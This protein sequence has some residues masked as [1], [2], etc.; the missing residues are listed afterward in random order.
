M[1]LCN[2]ILLFLPI[3]FS[4]TA[5]VDRN[6]LARDLEVLASD[7]YGGRPTG[8][9]EKARN[10]LLD[11]LK[12]V[13]AIYAQKVDTFRFMDRLKKIHKGY[14]VIVQI[15]GTRFTDQYLVLSAHY[16]HLGERDGKIYNGA[17]DN[18]S[19]TTALLELVRF[20][21]EHPTRHSIIFAFFDAEELGLKGADRFTEDPPVSLEQ[22][23]MNINLDMVSR[24]NDNTINICGTYEFPQLSK[25]LKKVIKKSDLTITKKHEGPEYRGANNWTGSSDHAMF[26]RK[27]IPYLY[28]GVED[29]PGYHAPSD[30][31]EF[32]NLDF[33]YQVTDLVRQTTQ[34]FDRKIQKLKIK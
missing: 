19:G 9:N 10:Y 31:F 8:N 15:E 6:R 25:P 14:N 30:D 21:K 1:H 3:C 18:A 2:L 29:H 16:D 5:Q 17:D 11:Q 7:E 27:D 12:D 24:N 4:L 13:N 23:L 32:I 33:F 26:A 34:Y 28:F 22:I 20:F